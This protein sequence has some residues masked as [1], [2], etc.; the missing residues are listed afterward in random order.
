MSTV[1]LR[2]IFNDM[3]LQE[4]EE[5]INKIIEPYKEKAN[6][7]IIED[8]FYRD[9]HSYIIKETDPDKTRTDK[10]IADILIQQM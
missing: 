9:V 3:Q 5:M 10:K 7:R 2:A 8:T 1:S 4:V 6:V